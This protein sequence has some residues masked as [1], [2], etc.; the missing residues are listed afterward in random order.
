M[1]RRKHLTDP[2]E[3]DAIT[4]PDYRTSYSKAYF[5]YKNFLQTYKNYDKRLKKART[6]E[7]EIRHIIDNEYIKL[8]NAYDPFNAWVLALKKSGVE[9]DYRKAKHIRSDIEEKYNEAKHNYL[10]SLKILGNTTIDEYEN[11]YVDPSNNGTVDTDYLIKNGIRKSEKAKEVAD[12]FNSYAKSKG[13]DRIIKNQ[14]KLVSWWSRPTFVKSAKNLKRS[15][16]KYPMTSYGVFD[17]DK[18]PTKG[19]NSSG[20]GYRTIINENPIYE[21]KT[22]PYLFTLPHEMMHTY[23][24]DNIFGPS[25]YG[26]QAYGLG[27]N[28]NTEPGHDSQL[29]EKHS[30]LE[31]LRF[32]LYEYGI[33]D[34]RGTIDATPE[35]IQKLRDKYPDIRPLK[36]MDNEKAAWMLNHVAQNNSK[37]RKH[38]DTY[39]A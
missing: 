4:G 27:H 19:V 18:F 7:N 2:P 32:M 8:T 14:G 1:S 33:Y 9:N 39:Y 5:D 36:Q 38:L 35:D 6:N 21:D 3:V 17:I 23:N 22:F 16:S 31:A 37:K 28:Q 12:Y 26:G 11:T 24:G 25:V 20:Y 13:I 15:L 30:D 10:N 29:N 34:S